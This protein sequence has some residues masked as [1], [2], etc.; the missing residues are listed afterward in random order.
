MGPSGA[1]KAATP[2]SQA[3]ASPTSQSSSQLPPSSSAKAASPQAGATT[4]KPPPPSPAK[5]QS[6]A[7]PQAGATPPK[8]PP[9]SPAKSPSPVSQASATE[10]SAAAEPQ[11][12]T[13]SPAKPPLPAPPSP[14]SQSAAPSPSSSQSASTSSAKSPPLSSLS[15]SPSP[16]A[17]SPSAS[18]ASASPPE[19]EALVKYYKKLELPKDLDTKNYR[20][21]IVE[22][23][24]INNFPINYKSFKKY[25][26]SNINPITV[27]CIVLCKNK[28]DNGFTKCGFK[29][30]HIKL[31]KENYN[32]LALVGNKKNKLDKFENIPGT[33]TICT[34]HFKEFLGIKM[35]YSKSINKIIMTAAKNFNK[36]DFV[37]GNDFLDISQFLPYYKIDNKLANVIVDKDQSKII[38][39]KEIKEG[40]ELILFLPN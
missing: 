31:K 7:P 9:P 14:T 19:A 12:P 2:V 11:I 29:N 33:F 10:T 38:A 36:D 4:Q 27:Q 28:K 34:K 8:S 24:K 40:E 22:E 16:P 18:A 35:K 37:C 39:K 3:G 15:A 5:S 13:A 32:N 20:N 1:T 26:T 21:E 6:P 23:M 25:S 30:T 17:P